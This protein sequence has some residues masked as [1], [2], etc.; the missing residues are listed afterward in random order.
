MTY[1]RVPYQGGTLP[2]RVSYAALYG[3]SLNETN[4][5]CISVIVLYMVRIYSILYRKDI[6]S[7]DKNP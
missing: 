7:R 5:D 2:G 6:N 4:V 3:N 1:T